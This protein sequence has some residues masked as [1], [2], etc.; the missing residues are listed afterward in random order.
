MSED[1]GKKTGS[2]AE[3]VTASAVSYMKVAEDD[4]SMSIFDFN[5]RYGSVEFSEIL[6]DESFN[7]FPSMLFWGGEYPYSP[8]G[9]I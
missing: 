4:E 8:R 9:K 6:E 3:I 7:H 1:M 2:V 5:F